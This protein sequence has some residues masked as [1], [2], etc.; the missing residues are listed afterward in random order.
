MNERIYTPEALA[1][2]WQC[3]ARHIRNLIN[4]GEL[5]GF[6]LG[7]KLLRIPVEAARE[8]E[9]WQA[10]NIAS[11]SSEADSVSTTTTARASDTDTSLSPRT[12]AELSAKRRAFTPS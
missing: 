12:R 7:G 8:Y 9:Q 1:A 4:K 5:R 6:R 3:S 11:G 10:N 2:E